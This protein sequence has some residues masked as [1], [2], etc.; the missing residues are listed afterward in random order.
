MIRVPRS[1]VLCI[2]ALALASTAWAHDF[3]IAPAKFRVA[4][5]EKVALPLRNGEAYV[6]APVARDDLRIERFVVLGPGVTEDVPGADK[7]DP[8]G[9]FT[10][11]ADGIWVAAYRSKPR[12]IELE[13][14]KFEAYV[15][16][17]GNEHV[18]KTRAE[19][20]ETDKVGREIYS[21]CA[22][23]LFLVGD[24]ATSEPTKPTDPAVTKAQPKP[25]AAPSDGYDR[26]VGMRLEIVPETNPF[27]VASGAELAFRV[28]YETK[29]LEGGLVVARSR[30]EPKHFVAARTAAD[31]RVRLKLDR[32]GEWL[33]TC[34][35]MIPAPEASGMDWESLWASLTF[36]L[37]AAK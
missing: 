31:G 18:A 36:D 14:A 7:Q 8:A 33:V 27:A 19:R 25:A 17:E 26:V 1:L 21:R 9:S 15:R 35:H 34:V 6:G 2:A 37:V 12:S 4:R 29:A 23:A 22:K 11:S 30:A 13:A 10:P 16:E 32:A 5:G 20:K 24:P 28:V 3:W